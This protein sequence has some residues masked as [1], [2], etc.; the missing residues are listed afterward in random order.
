M[1]AD[2][3][4]FNAFAAKVR[5][6]LDSVLRDYDIDDKATLRTLLSAKL[7]LQELSGEYQDGLQT[8][9]TLRALQEKPA[10]KL[11]A[12]LYPRARMQAA[13][14]TKT[15]NGPAYEQAFTKCFKE[16]VDPLPWDV[17]QDAMKESY[18]GSGSTRK[19]LPWAM[20][21]PSLIPRSRSRG[22]WT[23]RRP[24]I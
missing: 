7:D 12:F 4:T 14:E 16:A 5:A 8:V 20:W 15:T 2:D 17:V 1:Q 6:D 11:L 9:E 21:R 19:R 10:A 18:A 13:L 3:A 22:R 24:G 23:I